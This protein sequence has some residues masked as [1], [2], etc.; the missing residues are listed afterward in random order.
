MAPQIQRARAAL[1]AIN[2]LE[3]LRVERVNQTD[4]EQPAAGP[5]SSTD[6][7]EQPLLNRTPEEA[8]VNDRRLARPPSM[9]HSATSL[10]HC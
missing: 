9:L 6:G 7:P 10:A 5:S 8:V 1:R 4:E 2:R 3:T